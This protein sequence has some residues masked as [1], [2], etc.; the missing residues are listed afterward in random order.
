MAKQAVKQKQVV[1][2]EEKNNWNFQRFRL[3][4]WIIGIILFANTL[5]NGYNMDDNLVTQNHPVTSKGLEALGEIF[6]SPYYKD[7]MGY[8]YGYRPLVHVSFAFEH[9]FFG[10]KPAVSHFINLLIYISS[11]ILFFKL[12]SNWLTEKNLK[13]AFF[14]SL[15]FLVHP[16]HVETVASIKN[17]DELLAFFFAILAALS[18]L[19]FLKGGKISRLILVAMFFS[20]GMLSKKSIFPLVFV[21]PILF[22][23]LEEKLT[24]KQLS[25]IVV[26]FVVPASLIA[27]ELDLK[28]FV[29]AVGISVSMVATVF[30]L[31]NK[32]FE[33]KYIM[34]D[35]WVLSSFS[36]VLFVISM[37]WDLYFLILLPVI[38]QFFLLK[39]YSTFSIL[40]IALQGILLFFFF[41]Q[42]QLIGF[43]FVLL[44]SLLFNR[45]W[46]TKNKLYLYG[47]IAL[48]FGYFSFFMVKNGHIS[49][50]VFA[51]S[52]AF[53]ATFISFYYFRNWLFILGTALFILVGL[54]VFSMKWEV[55]GY[56]LI[57]NTVLV[58]FLVSL[59][60]LKIQ[61]KNKLY[62]W[63]NMGFLFILFT[64]LIP[65]MLSKESSARIFEKQAKEN[66]VIEI[67]LNKGVSEGRSLEYIEN[68]LV[69]Q[70]SKN[71]K[72]AT[73]LS[74]L[75]VY[76]EMMFFPNE[77]S[78]YYGFA[79][80]KTE[81]FSNW[82]VW[83]SLLFHLIL[84]VFGVINFKKWPILS[85]GIIWYVSS[86]M[87]FSNWVELVAGMVG[88]RL[89]Y[90]ASAGF[91]L[92]F[93]GLL[94]WF[95]EKS[96][97][98]TDKRLVVG[99]SILVLVL[100][101]RTFLRNKDWKDQLTLMEH[102]IKHLSTSAQANNLL[103]LNL[104]ANSLDEKSLTIKQKQD[105]QKKAITY[106]EKATHIW[107]EFFNAYFDLGRS[108]RIIGDNK[109]AIF[110]FKKAIQL[111]SS[112][113]ESY[114]NL[115][116]IYELTKQ[117]EAF[118]ETSES[119][120][121]VDSSSFAFGAL[122]RAYYLKKD[123]Q[124]CKLTLQDGLKKHPKSAD[125]LNNLNI[126][127]Q[128]IKQ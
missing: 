19:R 91:F 112:Y 73:G 55:D 109:R 26:V 20:A 94:V 67:K 24:W 115:L 47:I 116:E 52:A 49:M 122:A 21:L 59:I 97:F 108:A 8:S 105:Q 51:Q 92:F 56:G 71:E 25:S 83:V 38:I 37:Y 96:S 111:D 110:A 123:L 125:L 57:M 27:S 120:L 32:K 89:I 86:I 75:G 60:S 79:K 12:L 10:E 16:V 101:G 128:E 18:A 42:N 23:L 100:S 81:N 3:I 68:T 77:L 84:I 44:L 5:G 87:L 124:K 29:L 48:C 7:A 80:I 22:V 9:A 121:K 126:V 118:F 85:V 113:V 41:Q 39:N 11:V 104:M 64:G 95:Q 102:D 74:T 127:N 4:L 15:F 13:W 82:K 45:L 2:L 119:L 114:Y 50:Q 70:H 69:A 33:W 14:V 99:L 46:E 34:Q 93:I 28:K 63:M 72:I 17:R 53:V 36:W 76:A 90:T 35:K 58:L 88:E 61:Q 65:L 40:Q 117:N 66:S 30:V 31:K 103:A 98:L 54:F 62:H 6:T 1:E 43:T 106:F 107:P 78:F